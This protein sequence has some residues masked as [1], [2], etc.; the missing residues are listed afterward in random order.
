MFGMHFLGDFLLIFYCFLE[1][2]F[3][4]SD[5]FLNMFF[6]TFWD[7]LGGILGGIWEQ[8]ESYLVMLF[9]FCD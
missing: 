1:C 3:H 8:L 7:L 4:V 2:L 9:P 5:E 6:V